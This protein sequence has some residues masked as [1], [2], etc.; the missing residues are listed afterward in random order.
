MKKLMAPLL[1]LL[2][3]LIA[4]RHDALAQ[5]VFTGYYFEDP[6]SNPEDPMMGTINLVAPEG[7]GAFEAAMDFTLVGCQRSSTGR[8]EGHKTD[9]ILKG[10]WSGMTDGVEQTGAFSGEKEGDAYTGVYTVDGGKQH[11]VVP[12]CI[13]YHVA[14]QGEFTL[15]R[16]KPAEPDENGE[17]VAE[18]ERTRIA[19]DGGRVDVTPLDRN[20]LYV[21][22]ISYVVPGPTKNWKLRPA[23]QRIV[24]GTEVR[25]EFDKLKEE[26]DDTL[27]PYSDGWYLITA[28]S[29]NPRDGAAPVITELFFPTR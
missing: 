13:E 3:V 6:I 9:R 14:P 17:Y 19:T 24:Q 10:K 22:S 20:A 26:F 15:T 8:I 27:G 18:D 7:D 4:D 23:R 12:D 29:V 1:A 2:G 25:F 28:N 5:E 21:V 16:S 11:I